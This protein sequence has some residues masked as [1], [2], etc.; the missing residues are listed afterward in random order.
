MHG[1]DFDV[2]TLYPTVEF[3][4]PASTPMISPLMCWDHTE[5]W[6]VPYSTL[7]DDEGKRMFTID[8]NEDKHQY[9]Q[10][11]AVDGKL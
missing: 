4:V 3:P 8:V 11:H 1:L 10:G 9:L 7:E 2:A 6:F 5:D